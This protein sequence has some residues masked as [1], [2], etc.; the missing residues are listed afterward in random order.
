MRP[1][2]LSDLAR[3]L[4]RRGFESLDYHIGPGWERC[5][6]CYCLLR[7]HDRFDIFP[8]ERGMRGQSIFSFEVESDAC[9]NFVQLLERSPRFRESCVLKT[10][11]EKLADTVTSKLRANGLVVMRND[12]HAFDDTEFRVFVFSKD[13]AA[14]EALKAAGVI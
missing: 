2:T 9:E 4:E 7:S 10:K 3:Y 11:D 12:L 6:Q 14:V 1:T 5:A 13:V 8:V